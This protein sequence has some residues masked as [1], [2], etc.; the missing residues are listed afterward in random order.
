[1]R[2]YQDRPSGTVARAR[3]LRK[4]A[5]EPERRLLRAL[6]ESFPDL[7]WRHQVPIGPYYADILCFSDR[8]I[9]EVDGDTHAEARNYDAR[10]MTYLQ[11][12]GYR[13]I[14]FTNRDVMEN[15]D[16]V[17]TTIAPLLNDHPHPSALRASSLSLWEK[18][19]A[20]QAR[21]G[22]G[23]RLNIQGQEPRP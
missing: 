10:R 14:R 17:I 3:D 23:D 21:K 2:L 9:I 15:L 6:K 1:M 16:G 8:L 4:N 18:E 13:V 22:E 19:G 7:K 20:P 12:K 5:P 11:R